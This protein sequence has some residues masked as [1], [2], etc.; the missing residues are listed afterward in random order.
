MGARL[1]ELDKVIDKT[2]T[3]LHDLEPRIDTVTK[4]LEKLEGVVS[5]RLFSAAEVWMDSGVGD[6]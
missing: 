1:K 3:S 2:S 4:G 5:N 6:S